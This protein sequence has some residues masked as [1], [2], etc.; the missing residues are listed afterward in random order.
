MLNPQ[1][2]LQVPA[3]PPVVPA[4]LEWV[5]ER[6]ASGEEADSEPAAAEPAPPV[7]RQPVHSAWYLRLAF[8][9]RDRQGVPFRAP[10]LPFEAGIQQPAS[11]STQRY[12]TLARAINLRAP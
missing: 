10:P 7:Y 4:Q 1:P 5:V 2:L 12:S 6:P 9:Y 8:Q 11:S 3:Q